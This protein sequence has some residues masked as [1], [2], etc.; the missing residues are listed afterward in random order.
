LYGADTTW[1]AIAAAIIMGLSGV[2][3]FIFAVK[4]DYFHDFEEAKYQVFWN[5]VD[6]LIDS[7]SVASS[8]EQ[9]GKYDGRTSKER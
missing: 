5:D 7:A 9:E 3:L 1:V 2:C 8:K 6:E 4:R